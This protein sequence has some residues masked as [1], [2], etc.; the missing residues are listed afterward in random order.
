MFEGIEQDLKSERR[1]KNISFKGS[2][3]AKQWFLTFAEWQARVGV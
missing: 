3:F 2:R 1:N